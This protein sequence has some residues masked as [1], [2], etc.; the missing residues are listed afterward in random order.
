M[1][2]DIKKVI[3]NS[4]RRFSGVVTSVGMKDTV[5]V[6]IDRVAVH[7]RYKK[8]YTVSSRYPSDSKGMELKIGDKVLIEETRPL[9]KTK[10]WRVVSKTKVLNR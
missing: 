4:K 10:R 5:I 2:K 7:P 9:S 3:R 8:R 1:E 6:R